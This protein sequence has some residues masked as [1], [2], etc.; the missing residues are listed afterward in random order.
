M[1]DVGCFLKAKPPSASNATMS[2]LPARKPFFRAGI[3]RRFHIV[4]VAALLLALALLPSPA[5]RAGAVIREEG[6]IYLEDLLP[7]QVRL[8]TTADAPIY[9]KIDM[10]RYLGVLKKG[11]PVELQAIAEGSY[12]VRGKAQQGQVAGWIEPRFLTP[13]RP[14]FVQSL[15]ENAARRAEVEALI[16][17]NEVAVNMTPEEVLRALGK[18]A[19]KTSHVDGAGREEVWEFVRFERIPQEVI[20][21]DRY[22][23]LVKTVQYIKVPAGTLAITFSKNL[24]ASL[25][26]TEGT[27]EAAARVKIVAA[28]FTVI[29]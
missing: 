11:Q 15:R 18:P 1:L 26:Q 23:R 14:D 29:Y 8:L 9:Y 13:L 24:V 22:G 25:Q 6:A 7:K 28:P 10:E 21:Q 16:L 20:G 2:S 5:A 27:L 17:K 4:K 3:L 19:K 12:R